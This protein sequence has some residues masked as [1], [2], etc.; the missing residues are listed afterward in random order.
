MP[1]CEERQLFSMESDESP[2]WQ[3]W[4][5]LKITLEELRE[6]DIQ[7]IRGLLE[8]DDEAT[9]KVLPRPLPI[10]KSYQHDRS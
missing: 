6:I 10:D 3:G 4:Q 2:I 8:N 7:E 5:S 9:N 1:V